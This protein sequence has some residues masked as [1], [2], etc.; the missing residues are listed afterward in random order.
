MTFL[1]LFIVSLYTAICIG[2]YMKCSVCKKYINIQPFWIVTFPFLYIYSFVFLMINKEAKG[3]QKLRIVKLFVSFSAIFII[4]ECIIAAQN[5]ME[6]ELS[7][8][9]ICTI[10]V[11]TSK[12][13][14]KRHKNWFFPKFS[15]KCQLAKKFI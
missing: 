7:N 3:L 1:L 15:I 9:K 6:K 14:Q 4:L 5:D 8:K 10:N 11:Q 13:N 12:S 2:V